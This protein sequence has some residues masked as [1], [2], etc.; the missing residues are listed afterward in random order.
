MLKVNYFTTHAETMRLLIKK[1][2]FASNNQT[3]K[4]TKLM[5]QAA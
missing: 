1:L 3:L 5:Q 2:S 4:I